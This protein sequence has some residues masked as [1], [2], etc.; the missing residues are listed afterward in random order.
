MIMDLYEL[1]IASYLYSSMTK[2][3]PSF[4]KLQQ[5]T[6]NALNI[7]NREHCHSLYAWLNSWGCRLPQVEKDDIVELFQRWGDAF[8]DQLPDI[9]LCQFEEVD[10]HVVEEAFESLSQI[11]LQRRVFGPT[12]A[13]KVLF[14]LKPDA[15]SPWDEAIRD[16]LGIIANG[17]G[18]VGFLKKIRQDLQTLE[19][20]CDNFDMSPSQFLERI[21]R[22][23]ITPVQLLDEYFWITLT[24]ECSIPKPDEIMQWLAWRTAS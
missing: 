12:A 6:G 19:K 11:K 8:V 13:S 24:R 22:N 4:T 10:F 3:D 17:K 1:A 20:N 23:N 15:F 9:Q 14:I 16:G 7:H 2:F 18:Y 5:D 21:G